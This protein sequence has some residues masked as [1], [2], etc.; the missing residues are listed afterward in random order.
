M[1]LSFQQDIKFKSNPEQMFKEFFFDGGL[2]LDSHESKIQPNESPNMFNLFPEDSKNIKT[3]SGYRRYNNDPVGSSTNQSNTGTSTGTYSLSNPN[4][5]MAQSFQ[6]ASDADMVQANLYLAMAKANEEQLVKVELWSTSSGP[7]RRITDAQ[8]LNVSGTSE[9]A[10]TFRLRR[11]ETLTATTEYAIVVRPYVRG[12]TPVINE[13]LVHRTGDDYANGTAYSSA[14]G[15][16]TWSAESNDLKFAILTGVVA[17]SG[18]IRYYRD[19]I[20]QTIAKHG[21]TY[22]RGNDNTGAMTAITMPSGINTSTSFIDWTVSNGTL[23]LVDKQN[24]I[25]KYR[26]STNAN[27]STGTIS[28]TNN[29]ATVT[30]SSTVWNTTTNAET[31]EYIQLPDSKWYKIVSISSDTSLTIETAYRGSTASGQSYVISPWGEVQG[32]LSSNLAP[33]SLIRPTPNFI[34]THLNRVWT[35]EGNTLRFSSLDTSIPEENFND[36]DT[37]NNAGT[38]ILDAGEGDTGTG[39]YSL[40]NSLFVFQRRAIWRVYGNSPGNFEIRNISNEVGLIDRR[41]LVEWDEILIFLSDS[42]V[43]FFDGSNLKS[44]SDDKVDSLIE[45]WANKTSPVATLW[46]N[47]YLLAY[48]PSGDAKNSE[49]LSLSLNDKKWTRH[50]GILANS[51]SVWRGGNDSNEVFFGSSDNGSIYRWGVGGNDDGYE[52]ESVYDTPSIGYGAGINDKAIKKVFV[53]QLAKGD[54][55][56]TVSQINN[57]DEEEI[58]SA[59]VNLSGGNVSLWDTM[60]WDTDDW[61]SEQGLITT[62]IAEFQGIAKYFKF[63]M[64]QKGYDEGME[65]V[66]MVATARIRR[67]N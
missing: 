54:W 59:P 35:L 2:S 37:G 27:Y 9:T 19:S 60:E 45:T 64:Y 67:L 53:Q 43:Y 5:L 32:K 18:L 15:G 8:I 20:A 47:K 17:S 41:T 24:R 1:A 10:Y 12:T 58:V 63:R 44:M 3:R 6:V 16:I 11:S 51:F 4:D 21:S 49:L 26:G 33:S 29:S 50:K 39:I 13:V 22:Y 23:L 31:G 7:D 65:V 48:T 36:F 34:A 55:N 61:S 62:R 42:G 38:I 14:N 28:V 52:I 46:D 66:G 25:K 40:N 56:M 30:G 57:F